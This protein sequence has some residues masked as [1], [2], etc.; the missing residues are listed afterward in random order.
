MKI[1]DREK[2]G[3]RIAGEASRRLP[4]REDGESGFFSDGMT[5]V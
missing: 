2:F 1:T 3:S 5:V 4:L